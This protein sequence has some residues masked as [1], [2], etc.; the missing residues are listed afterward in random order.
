MKSNTGV[1]LG[2]VACRVRVRQ[3]RQPRRTAALL[4]EQLVLAEQQAERESLDPT[5]VEANSDRSSL[6]HSTRA[7]RE[8]RDQIHQSDRSGSMQ[9][10]SQLSLGLRR[11]R[12][13]WCASWRYRCPDTMCCPTDSL[14]VYQMC[15]CAEACVPL[16]TY[17]CVSERHVRLEVRL[18][19]TVIASG[20]DP[21][22]DMT[23]AHHSFHS[24]PLHL[25]CVV[26][27]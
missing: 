16:D 8:T 13:N 12:C 21:W 6:E 10:S 3:H 7:K 14:R 20:G 11:R 1:E 23:L 9:K 5:D 22:A 26:R 18:H 2:Q 17:G 15:L 4:A 25:C 19:N 24:S 27:Q